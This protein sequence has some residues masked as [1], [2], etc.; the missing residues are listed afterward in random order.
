MLR[1]DLRKIICK[2]ERVIYNRLKRG[3][4]LVPRGSYMKDEDLTQNNG[5]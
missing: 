3:S 2:R 4:L 5:K 1:K